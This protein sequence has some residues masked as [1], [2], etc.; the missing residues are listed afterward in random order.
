M[1]EVLPKIAELRRHADAR[2]FESLDI[3]VDGGI[4]FETAAQCAAHGANQFVA[5]S[6]LF[7]QGDMGAAVAQ[8]RAAAA[9]AYG[10]AV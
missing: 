2:G 1:G 5:G 7:K 8:M 4:T 3:M 6:F 10:S 9:R